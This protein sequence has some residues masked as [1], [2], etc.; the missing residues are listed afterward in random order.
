[1]MG[2][3]AT[4]LPVYSTPMKPLTAL[5]LSLALTACIV[6]DDFGTYWGKGTTDA[7]INDI[8]F[9]SMQK[10]NE[11]PSMA[12]LTQTVRVL[13]LGGHDFI[14][15]RHKPGDKGGDLVRY[16]IDGDDY[17]SYR[18]NEEKRDDFMNAHPDSPVVVT[19]ETATIKVLNA[20]TAKL[21][22]DIA[23]DDSYWI[24]ASRE[25]YNPNHRPECTHK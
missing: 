2:I 21:L 1:M 24:E 20:D 22:V 7:C 19:E 18:L 5:L 25:P 12:T 23:D 4:C 13:K 8:L 15:M 17:V 11:A 6:V 9:G 16:R 3:A 14:M 10:D